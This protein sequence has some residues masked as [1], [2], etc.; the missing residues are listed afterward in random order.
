MRA[1]LG[2]HLV[3]LWLYICWIMILWIWNSILQEYMNIWL[4]NCGRWNWHLAPLGNITVL[5]HFSMGLNESFIL[6]IVCI[7]VMC[8]QR[9]L[10]FRKWCRI[11][12]L[13]RVSMYWHVVAWNVI[14]THKNSD[15]VLFW[16][17]E[18]HDRA[19]IIPCAVLNKPSIHELPI[20]T[21]I[22]ICCL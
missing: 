2:M 3:T 5:N 7:Q 8:Q 21:C 9:S 19:S 6:V 13:A 10:Q 14:C 4:Y 18:I 1:C 20:N 17:R 16:S 22:Y 12:M 15:F 11:S